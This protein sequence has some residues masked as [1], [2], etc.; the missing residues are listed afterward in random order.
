MSVKNKIS[1]LL[2]MVTGLTVTVA[3]SDNSND[4][5]EWIWDT[6]NTTPEEQTT[7]KPRYIWVDAAANFP[8][9]A[10]SQE[11][12]RKDLGKVK[13]TGFTDVVIDVRPT[14]GD[15]LF[16]SSVA[17]PVKKLDVWSATGY[18][19]FER[20]ATWD[21]L[22]AFIDAGHDHGLRVHASINTFVGGNKYPYG[23]GEQGFLFRDESKKEWATTLNLADG[24]INVMDITDESY[25]TKFL[26]PANPEVRQYML[27]LLKDLAKYEVD[28][29]FLDRCRYDDFQSDFSAASRK[30]FEEY[31]GEAIENYPHDIIEPGTKY[32][33]LPSTMPKHFKKWLEFR[34]KTIHDFIVDAKAVIKGQNEKIQVG[35]YVGGWYSTYY[36]VGVNWGSPKY[37]TAAHYPKWA[38]ADYQKFGYADHLDFL[39]L[40]AYAGVDHIYGN[41]EWNIQGFCKNARQILMDDVK[42]AGGPDVGNGTGWT[43]GGK[44]E[45]VTKTVDACINSGDGYFVFDIVHVKKYD[46][47]LNLKNGI[48]TYLSSLSDKSAE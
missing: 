45:E 4:I 38:S 14:M 22:Q 17:D 27:D 35:V 8:D 26:N 39:L 23:L 44:G 20:T 3:C 15:V 31:I 12:I 25:G 7:E 40:G 9:Y 30:G 43:D 6:P 1:K 42:F 16:A 34:A 2:L 37:P 10:N 36:E 46:Y 24:L 11:N 41:G 19:Y 48:D 33:A 47:W 13:D 5:P 29:I 18:D 21:Y 28:G 32:N